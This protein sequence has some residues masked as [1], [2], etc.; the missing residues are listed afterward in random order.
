MRPP[1]EL[2]AAIERETEKADR[3]AL[4]RA[5]DELT[6]R[7][8]SADFSAPII[9]SEAHRAAYMAARLPA[10]YAANWR[11]FSEI[12]RLAPQGRQ[13]IASALDLGAGPGTALWA[14]AEVF[15]E[16]RQATLV[17]SDEAWL[18]L[19]R[20]IAAN[21][22]HSFLRHAEWVRHDL[23]TPLDCPPHDLVVISYALG[24][25]SPPAAQALLLRAWS[26]ASRF[27]VVIEPGTPRGFG[28][29]HTARSALIAATAASASGSQILAP[30]PHQDACPMA[31]AGDWCHFAQRVPRT[32]LHR[33]LKS[34]ALAYEDEKFSYIVASRERSQTVLSRIVRHPQKRTGHVQLTLCTRRG[35]E[36]RTVSRSQG[37]DYLLARQAQWGDPWGE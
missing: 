1:E 9:K 24:E 10:T 27:L 23:R 14:A 36:R 35:I 30:C 12:C 29:I 7:Y 2:L 31:A 18:K 13:E 8:K 19:G 33:R 25:L 20:R 37:K 21:S 16:L 4:A 11:V 3:A 5:S 28:V 34:G 15:P 32:S 6:R 26:L 17:E 22:P